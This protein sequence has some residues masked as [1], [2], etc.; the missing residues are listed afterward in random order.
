MNILITNVEWAIF[1]FVSTVVVPM[2]VTYGTL[3]T[4]LRMYG[5]KFGALKEGQDKSILERN[6]K[7]KLLADEVK[8]NRLCNHKEITSLSGIVDNF[9][10]TT[11]H[12]RMGS[13][14]SIVEN[15]LLD[16]NKMPRFITVPICDKRNQELKDELIEIKHK[17]ENKD[18][19][20]KVM[21]NEILIAIKTRND[22]NLNK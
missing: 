9:I 11:C 1:G 4:L 7:I 17:I 14:M 13:Q 19:T 16:S 2:A 8:E 6:E 20:M 15:Y 21:L 5:E 10:N 22:F 18:E 12:N 3:K